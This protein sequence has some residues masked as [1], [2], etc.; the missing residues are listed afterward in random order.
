MGKPKLSFRGCRADDEDAI[1]PHGGEYMWLAAELADSLDRTDLATEIRDILRDPATRDENGE[2]TF[3]LERVAALHGLMTTVA[4][5]LRA[6]P[7]TWAE[8]L[9]DYP[10]SRVEV[11][12][13]YLKS[14]LER[15]VE[16]DHGRYT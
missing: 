14:A 3:P 1:L 9:G 11:V 7:E 15:G 6:A 8:P 16:V 12:A 4:A 5:L 10:L 13:E 2:A